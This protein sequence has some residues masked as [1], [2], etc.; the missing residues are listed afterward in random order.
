[1][2]LPRRP[3]QPLLRRDLQRVRLRYSKSGSL[4]C[5]EW[6][7]GLSRSRFIIKSY[8]LSPLG[9]RG[10]PLVVLDSVA[11]ATAQIRPQ[12]VAGRFAQEMH[13]PSLASAVVSIAIR[14]S[15]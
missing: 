4:S 2:Q 1:M 5:R 6:S 8:A 13:I 12:A 10:V 9:G 15:V 3:G 7:L 11:R 14:C